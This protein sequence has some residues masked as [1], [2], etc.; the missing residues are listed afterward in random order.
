[1]QK[2]TKC[3]IYDLYYQPYEFAD[4]ASQSDLTACTNVYLPSKDFADGDDPFTFITADIQIEVKITEECA[5]CHF[6]QR[7]QCQLDSNGRFY[8]AEGILNQTPWKHKAHINALHHIFLYTTLSSY[9]KSEL[10][11]LIA[12]RKGLSRNAKLGIGNVPF[13]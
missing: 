12:D 13:T 7:G 1:M 2:Y 4:N 9:V 8:C 3:A 10:F 6:N 11:P 5:H